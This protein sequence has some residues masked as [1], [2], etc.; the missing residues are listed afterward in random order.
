MDD[1]RRFPRFKVGVEVTWKK[2]SGAER[3]ALHISQ[4][5]DMSAGG[6]CLVLHS[7]IEPGDVLRLEIAVSGQ[8]TLQVNGKVVWINRRAPVPGRKDTAC[9]GG[10]EFVGITEADKKTLEQLIVHSL[11]NTSHK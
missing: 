11:G 2:I 10:V 5:K 7:G 9:E 1:R 6:V 8:P 3:A 4:A